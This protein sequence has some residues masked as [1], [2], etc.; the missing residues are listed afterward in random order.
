[1]N[2]NLDLPGTLSFKIFFTNSK[3]FDQKRVYIAHSYNTYIPF[4]INSTVV[5]ELFK[6]NNKPGLSGI[7]IRWNFICGV[8]D[9]LP[10]YLCIL[11]VH[12]VTKQLYRNPKGKFR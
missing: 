10:F 11:I 5:T 12:N 2:V 9:S 6:M 3:Y 4:P 1:M 8:S 7:K